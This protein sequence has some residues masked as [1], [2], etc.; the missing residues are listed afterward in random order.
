MKRV[1]IGLGLVAGAAFLLWPETTTLPP[2]TAAPPAASTAPPVQ[3]AP[4]PAVTGEVTIGRH[5]LTVR[6]GLL[7]PTASITALFNEWLGNTQSRRYEEW[8]PEA[9]KQAAS[10]PPAAQAQL[11]RWLDQYVELNLAMQLMTVKGEPSWD[12]ILANV[13]SM[14]GEYFGDEAASLFADQIALENFTESAV[15]GF[16]DG[17]NPLSSLVDLEQ[18]ASALPPHARAR[19]EALLDQLSNALQQDPTLNENTEEWNRLV[20]ANAAAS[21]ETPSV[22]LT[23]ANAGFL[24]RYNAYA[25]E[26]EALQQQGA[27]EEQLKALRATRFSDAELLR[28]GTLDRA[29]SE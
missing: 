25:E 28:A 9:L 7:V 2:E 6:D 19:A 22:D 24:Q 5:S 11:A 3:A 21:L 15:T 16:A 27:T 12:N 18:Q 29:L 1:I 14:R 13:R 23:E 26:R 20:Q 4:T 8:K 17:A 10:L